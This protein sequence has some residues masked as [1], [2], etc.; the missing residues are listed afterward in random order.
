M[1]SDKYRMKYEDLR[2][3]IKAG[4]GCLIFAKDTGRIL[5]ILRSDLVS[6]PLSWSFPGGSL[7][8]GEKPGHAARREVI[9]E[10]GID[11]RNS[12]LQ[13]LHVND[14]HAPRFRFYTF[15][16]VIDR[17]FEPVLN[18]E[19]AAYKWCDPEDLPEPLHWGVKQT[20]D[21]R[22]AGKAFRRFLHQHASKPG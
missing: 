12:R 8:K 21:N 19:S 5:L 11:L 13:L 17:E 22:M 16:T 4:A 20:L 10:T 18:W 6:S 9:E 1:L 3:A 2:R 15:A 14:Y 7:E